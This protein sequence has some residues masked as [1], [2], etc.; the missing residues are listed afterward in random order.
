MSGLWAA[1]EASCNSTHGSN[2]LGANSTS[3]CLVWGKI[4]GQLAAQYA[5]NKAR[6]SVKV[7]QVQQEEKESTMEFSEVE[8]M[9]ILTKYERH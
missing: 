2:R 5:L 4:T 3:E 1:G 9:L 8:V 7:V 6:L